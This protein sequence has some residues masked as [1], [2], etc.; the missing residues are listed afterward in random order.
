M[1]ARISRGGGGFNFSKHFDEIRIRNL[2]VRINSFNL[3]IEFSSVGY[4]KMRLYRD[5]KG[6]ARAWQCKSFENWEQ[7]Y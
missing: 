1:G 2:Y 3:Q 6:N 5:R 4:F 7:N